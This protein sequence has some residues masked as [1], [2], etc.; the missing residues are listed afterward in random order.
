M[1]YTDADM[2]YT[3]ASTGP[4]GLQR[5]S[6]VLQP[7]RA[8]RRVSLIVFLYLPAGWGTRPSQGKPQ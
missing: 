8:D 5:E 4:L 1:G 2:G 6:L 7:E 3:D